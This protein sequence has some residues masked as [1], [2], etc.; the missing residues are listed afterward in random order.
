MFRLLLEL[1]LQT[2]MRVSDAVRLNP[3]LAVRSE[4][5]WSYSFKAHKRRKDTTPKPI[6]VY[7]KDE[8]MKSIKEENWFSTAHPFAYRALAKKDETDYLSQ[9]VY[10]RM[11][12]IRS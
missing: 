1:M 11:Q 4:R 9:A 6:T 2:G 7:I 3:S 12:E 10:E 5:M 8:L